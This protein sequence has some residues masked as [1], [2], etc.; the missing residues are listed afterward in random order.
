MRVLVRTV[1]FSSERLVIIPAIV[2]ANPSQG[3]PISRAASE[4]YPVCHFCQS[5]SAASENIVGRK[6]VDRKST[7]LNSSHGYISYA[8]FCLKKKNRVRYNRCRSRK[9]NRPALSLPVR[10]KRPFDS[11]LARND[12]PGAACDLDRSIPRSRLQLLCA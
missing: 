12:G 10:K 6:Y 1:A 2:I 4:K 7:R 11:A 8:V 3:P 9:A 5:P